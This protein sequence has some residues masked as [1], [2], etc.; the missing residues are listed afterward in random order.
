MN[1]RHAY[2]AV[3]FV[4]WTCVYGAS[5]LDEDKEKTAG[6][7]GKIILQ[8]RGDCIEYYYKTLLQ[9]SHVLRYRA[10]N[11]EE[12]TALGI[13]YLLSRGIFNIHKICM[14][15]QDHAF[16]A[17]SLK[18]GNLKQPETIPEEA[19]IVDPWANESYPAKEFNQRALEREFMQD[20]PTIEYFFGPDTIRVLGIQAWERSSRLKFFSPGEEQTNENIAAKLQQFLFAEMSARDVIPQNRHPVIDELKFCFLKSRRKETT[21]AYQ[22]YKT[23]CRKF[24]SQLPKYKRWMENLF[25]ELGDAVDKG[26]LSLDSFNIEPFRI[27]CPIAE[28]YP[29][30]LENTHI[31]IFK[32]LEDTAKAILG[33]DKSAIVMA[34]FKECVAAILGSKQKS[35]FSESSNGLELNSRVR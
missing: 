7:V 8:Y 31:I 4:K 16:L 29:P 21:S 11:C 10:G 25:D 14:K 28:F 13:V 34:K 2:T 27:S 15:K 26:D 5:T 17:I 24:Y 23:Y 20:D 32:E 30:N 35:T 12:Q 3:R 18:D 19:M 22:S 6:L 33:K 9:A 1:F